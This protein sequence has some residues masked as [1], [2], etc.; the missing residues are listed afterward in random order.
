[1][2]YRVFDVDNKA[3]YTK[4]MSFDELKDY[5]EPDVEIFDEEM[6]DKWE[7]INDVDDLREFLE[8]KAD[9]R[10]SFGN[11]TIRTIDKKYITSPEML[12]SKRKLRIT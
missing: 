11:N 6:H 5:F 7:E 3:E 4:G 1:M 2:K 8:Y 12:S 9:E 10:T